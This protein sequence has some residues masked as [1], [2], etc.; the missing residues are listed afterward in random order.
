MIS[1]IGPN[2]TA[3]APLNAASGAIKPEVSGPQ[4][5][6]LRKSARE[7]ESMMVEQIWKGMKTESD[8]SGSGHSLSDMASHALA[9]GVAARG[10]FG[11]AKM[12]LHQLAPSAESSP[13][14]GSETLK[15]ASSSA[16]HGIGDHK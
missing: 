1:W 12:I 14:N 3:P 5:D 16:D 9:V 15:P 6:K 11:I 7:F 13:G 2:T 4:L 10:G 8:D